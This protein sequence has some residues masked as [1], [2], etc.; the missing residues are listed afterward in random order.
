M[1]KKIIFGMMLLSCIKIVN[2][3]SVSVSAS[4]NYVTS[5]SS[6][7]FYV[8]ISGAAWQLSGYSAGATSGCSLG[9]EGVGDSGTGNN[10]NKTLSVSC[11]ATS[12]GQISFTVTGNV[13]DASGNAVDVSGSKTVTVGAPRELDSNNNLSSLGV[14]GYKIS[15]A[16]SADTLEYS[17]EVPSTVNDVNITGSPASG[18]ASIAG[19]GKK[20]VNEGANLFIITVTSE[21]GVPK[22]YKL[23]VNVKDENP[24]KVVLGDEEYTVMKN[25]KNIVKPELYEQTTI[26]INNI[27]IPAF[28]NETTNITLVGVKDSKGNVRLA[29]YDKDN[30][31]YLLYE[32]NKSDQMILLIHP[33]SEIKDGYIKSTIRIDDSEYDCLKVNEESE[34]AII[35]ATNLITGEDDYY[36]YDSKENSYIRY[37]EEQLEPLK[38]ELT[39]YKDVIKYLVIGLGVLGLLLIISLITRPR[40]NKDV[41]EKN[42]KDELIIKDVTEVEKKES[43]KKLDVKEEEKVPEEKVVKKSKKQSQKDAIKSVEEATMIIENFEKKVKE[44]ELEKQQEVEEETMYDIFEDDRKRKKKTK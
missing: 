7:T 4:S 26:K 17:V 1:K 33:I 14:E 43:K 34:Y 41:K 35:Y 30:E 16:F 37:N 25:A 2:A 11:R 22:E 21:T 32:E 13:T 23:T 19:T 6:V 10:V 24:I 28:Y 20:E 27:E 31:S 42:K 40:K 12:V 38:E 44:K 39:K 3:A 8:N 9:D 29:I 5:G 36:L 18:Y 15:P